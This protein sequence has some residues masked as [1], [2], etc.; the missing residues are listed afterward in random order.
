[1]GFIVNVGRTM[2]VAGSAAAGGSGSGRKTFDTFS[3]N[4]LQAEGGGIRIEREAEEIGGGAG[5]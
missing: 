4:S 2:S 5:T 3:Q 1:L